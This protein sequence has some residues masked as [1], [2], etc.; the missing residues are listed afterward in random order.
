M[1]VDLNWENEEV[2]KYV[3][4]MMYFWFEKGI[5]G[6]RFDVINLIFKDQCFLNVEDGDDGCSFY[7]DGLWVYEFLYEMNEK[8]FLYYNS[9]MV[10]EMFLIIVDYCI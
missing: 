1:Q 4:D 3:Y 9:M 7:I 5:D 8:V 10:G 2:R 6:F